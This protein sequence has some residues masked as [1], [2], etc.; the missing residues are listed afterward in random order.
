VGLEFEYLKPFLI[1]TSRGYAVI[2]PIT[3]IDSDESTLNLAE[4]ITVKS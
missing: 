4:E 2:T 3:R 1:I